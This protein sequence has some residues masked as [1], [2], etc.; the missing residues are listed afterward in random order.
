[1][2][3]IQVAQMI[4]HRDQNQKTRTQEIEHV[5]T[6][7][8]YYTQCKSHINLMFLLCILLVLRLRLYLLRN[9]VLVL[10]LVYRV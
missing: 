10:R 9:V 4:A 8:R 5:K 7:L 3:V 2:T 6:S 1:M